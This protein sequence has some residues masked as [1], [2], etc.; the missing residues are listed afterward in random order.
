MQRPRH[1]RSDVEEIAV[2]A[3][4]AA[5]LPPPRAL[6]PPPPPL[7]PGRR[8]AVSLSPTVARRCRPLVVA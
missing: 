4:R 2:A 3:V 7:M 8:L 5:V 1:W 6:P